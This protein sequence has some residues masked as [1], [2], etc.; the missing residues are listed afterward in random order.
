[1]PVR[2]DCQVTA[3]EDTISQIPHKMATA[4]IRRVG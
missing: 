3:R 1:M 4:P 2:E